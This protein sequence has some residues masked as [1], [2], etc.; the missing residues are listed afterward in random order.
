M[1]TLLFLTYKN[2]LSVDSSEGDMH[3][4]VLWPVDFINCHNKKNVF[5]FISL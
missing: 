1:T 5:I 2:D 3:S 4:K